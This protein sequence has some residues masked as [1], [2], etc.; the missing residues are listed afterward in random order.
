MRYLRAE[1]CAIAIGS[2]ATAAIA[3]ATSRRWRFTV[4]VGAL[5]KKR[6]YT[7]A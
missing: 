7:F 3:A 2:A 1:G 5:E 6:G 4:I